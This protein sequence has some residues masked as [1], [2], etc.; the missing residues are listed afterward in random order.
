[1][2]R[3]QSNWLRYQDLVILYD[4]DFLD[5]QRLLRTRRIIED[6]VS[7]II[8][9]TPDRLNSRILQEVRSRSVAARPKEFEPRKIK[10]CFEA[11]NKEVI[12]NLINPFTAN[13]ENHNPLIKQ[14]RDN[15]NVKSLSIEGEQFTS[16][17]EGIL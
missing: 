15:F 10:S 14:V 3:T 17:V 16:N 8:T 7:N 11:N 2:V 9:P 1:M 13:D 5:R 12:R 4:H 6:G